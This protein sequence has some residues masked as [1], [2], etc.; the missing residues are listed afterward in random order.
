MSTQNRPAAKRA[1]SEAAAQRKRRAAKHI[2]FQGVIV[3]RRTVKDHRYRINH[4]LRASPN[5]ASVVLPRR[6]PSPE[7]VV[8]MRLL[9]M[10]A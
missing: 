6:G 4:G 1:R 3:D 10:A 9:Q 7:F 5:V 2:P 8:A